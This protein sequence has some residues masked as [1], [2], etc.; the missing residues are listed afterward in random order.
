MHLAD[1]LLLGISKLFFA[2]TAAALFLLAVGL[3][4]VAVQG[5]WSSLPSLAGA[6]SHMTSRVSRRISR[7]PAPV[8]CAMARCPR[9]NAPPPAVRIRA[10]RLA[11]PVPCRNSRREKKDLSR[12][13]MCMT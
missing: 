6:S 3:V 12:A 2:V 10:P 8:P 1:R 7:T 13:N 5:T 9:N 4:A 11:W